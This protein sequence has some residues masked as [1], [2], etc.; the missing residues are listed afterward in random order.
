MLRPMFFKRSF[1]ALPLVLTLVLGL[2]SCGKDAGCNVFGAENYSPDAVIDDGSCIE[3]RDKFIGQ[4]SVTSDCMV[5]AYLRTIRETSDRFIVEI[6]NIGDTLGTVTAEVA[7]PNITIHVQPVRNNVTVEG[8]GLYFPEEN[9]L[10]ISYTVRDS[11]SGS[12]VA[13]DCLDNCLKN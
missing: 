1:I 6:T 8:A 5:G 13:F 7:G 4:Y 12:L 10:S 11:R 9:K 3:V 2:D